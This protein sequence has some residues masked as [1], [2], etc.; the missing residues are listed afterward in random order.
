EDLQR[1]LRRTAPLDPVSPDV[2]ACALDEADAGHRLRAI[3]SRVP[4][5]TVDDRGVYRYHRLFRALL[6]DKLTAELGPDGRRAWVHR[7]ADAIAVLEA[8]SLRAETAM[9]AGT[10]QRLLARYRRLAELNFEIGRTREGIRWLRQS[11]DVDVS[12]RQ[13]IDEIEPLDTD[14]SRVSSERA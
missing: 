10:D 6:L 11:G 12:G 5:L 7:L 1:F 13:A 4:F 9:E 3:A 14:V 8:A 2:V